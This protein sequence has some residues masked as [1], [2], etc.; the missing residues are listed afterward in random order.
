MRISTA[1]CAILASLATGCSADCGPAAQLASRTYSVFTHPV[2]ATGNNLKA[3]TA[4]PNFASYGL[5]VNGENLWSFE[6]GAADI[7]PVTVSI[8][9]QEYE[10]QG[11]WDSVECGSF[12][13]ENLTGQFLAPDGTEHDFSAAMSMVVFKQQLEGLVQW[14]EAWT[15]TDGESGTYRSTAQMR[16][17]LTSGGGE[18]SE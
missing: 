12:T 9:G 4:A 5:P 2:S 7:G 18:A 13:V 1:A 8:D 14:N 10:G 11:V 15:L 6:F 3:L 16:G 17:V